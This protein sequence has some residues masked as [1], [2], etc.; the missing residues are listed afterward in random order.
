MFK[1]SQ[2]NFNRAMTLAEL[3][4]VFVIMG[5]VAS[6]ILV[7]SKPS[8]SSLKYLYLRIYNVLGVAFYNSSVNIPDCFR[9]G[10][11]RA[12]ELVGGYPKTSEAFCIMLLDYINDKSGGYNSAT[13]LAANCSADAVNINMSGA[14]FDTYLNQKDSDGNLIH[15]PHFVASNGSRFWIA[16]SKTPNTYST[17]K[18]HA[19]NEMNA[20]VDTE[21]RGYIVIVD[22]NGEAVP[23]TTQWKKN[24]T[25]DIVAFIVMEDFTVI[26]IGYP[27]V[28]RRYLSASIAYNTSSGTGVE[29]VNTSVFIPY[30]LAKRLAWG[31]AVG[32]SNAYVTADDSMSINYYAAKNNFGDKNNNITSKS[33]FYIDYSTNPEF[34]PYNNMYFAQEH[35]DYNYHKNCAKESDPT[36]IQPD[37][38]YLTIKDYY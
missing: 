1:I 32:A 25:A 9:Q 18:F 14:A 28:D 4:V 23:N 27:E 8:E 17:F 38:C 35:D 19:S 26:P 31:T 33:V 13:D 3:L 2:K 37:A 29:D 21:L 12:N 6:M 20:S 11:A 5:I 15:P 22:L 30:Y 7:T 16:Y 10:N 24:K 34:T 36:Q